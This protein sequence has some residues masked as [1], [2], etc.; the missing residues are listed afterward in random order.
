MKYHETPVRVR[1]NEVDAYH[2]AWHGHY[3]T[4]MEIGRNDLAGR[5]D[6][7]ADQVDALGPDGDDAVAHDDDRRVRVP[8]DRQRSINGRQNGAVQSRLALWRPGNALLSRRVVE[9]RVGINDSRRHALFS[10]I[11]Y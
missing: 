2:V 11:W 9:V 3:V 5:F 7:N 6:L 8:R 4:W 1:F 10:C